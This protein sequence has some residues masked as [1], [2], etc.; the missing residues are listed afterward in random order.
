MT[1]S[2]VQPRTTQWLLTLLAGS[3]LID[4]LLTVDNGKT[5]L[6]AL[7]GA[8]LLGLCALLGVKQP[9]QGAV[10]GSFVLLVSTAFIRLSHTQP[11]SISIND[12]LLTEVAAG[13]TLVV[14]VVWRTPPIT[15]AL[16]TASLVGVAVLATFFR[17]GKW[18]A[19][20][21]MRSLQLGLLIL[22]GAVL[23]GVYLRSVSGRRTET[24]LGALIRRQ[25][26]LAAALTLMLF[27]DLRIGGT[28]NQVFALG[29]AV[30]ASVCAFFAPRAPVVLSLIAT[31]AI[32][33]SPFV[34]FAGGI[35]PGRM[36]GG[37]PVLTEIAASMALI[38]FTVR[39]APRWP[40]VFSTAAL[41]LATFLALQ[42]RELL[43]RTR[44][45]S[46]ADEFSLYLAVLLVVAVATGMYFRSRDRERTQSVRSAVS[47]AQQS[48]RLALARELH[49]VVA[50]HVTGIVVQAQAAALVSAKDPQVAVKALAKIETSGVEAL[51]AM[52]FL[53]AS[54]RGAKPAGTSEATEQ[55]TTDLTADLRAMIENFSGPAVR[56][57]LDVPQ[58]VPQEVGRSVLRLVQESL[59]NV[60][61]HALGATAVFVDVVTSAAEIHVKVADNGTGRRQ[62][63][64]GGS[65]GYGLVG[66][67][68]RVELLGGRF[69]AGPADPVGWQVDAWLPVGEEEDAT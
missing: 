62:D 37:G 2:P 29:G 30:I 7:P 27:L 28:T 52:R 6:G 22:V 4:V 13:I 67:R 41:A 55:A 65:G 10:G 45:S 14:L 23:V 44:V 47:G 34:M 15:A 17:T 50:H 33:L 9:V 11:E 51:K 35:L 3:F 20:G 59:T 49:D 12:I 61:K 26:P 1:V 25:W 5:T 39:W 8:A 24:Q 21:N 58:V 18:S 16:C 19:S 46:N 38:A 48:E 32:A 40:A 69:A 68:E 56:L 60:G 31:A 64:V 43:D 63:P 57:N 66:M 36:T 54:M 42:L 53:V